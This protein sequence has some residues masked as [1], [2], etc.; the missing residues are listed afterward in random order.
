MSQKFTIAPDGSRVRP[1]IK[2]IVDTEAEITSII[3]RKPKHREIMQFGDPSSMIIMDGALSPHEDMGIVEKYVNV[4]SGDQS[5]AKIL[6]D[7]LNQLEYQDSLA[8]KDAVLS[9]FKEAEVSTT[10][11][12]APKN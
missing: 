4:L 12:D 10:S 8:L 5:G 9:F 3:L 11:A 1:L 2:P 7:L 6:P